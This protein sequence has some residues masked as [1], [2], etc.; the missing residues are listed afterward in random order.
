MSILVTHVFVYLM[1]SNVSQ[2]HVICST[3]ISQSLYV[4]LECCYEKYLNVE[5]IM[6]IILIDYAFITLHVWS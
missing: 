2:S 1:R 6:Y 3:S 4:A 5:N